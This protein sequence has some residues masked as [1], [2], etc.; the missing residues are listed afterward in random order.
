M[1]TEDKFQSQPTSEEAFSEMVEELAKEAQEE[2]EQEEKEDEV[3]YSR[4][5]YPDDFSLVSEEQVRELARKHFL[6]V[7]RSREN[8][9]KKSLEKIIKRKEENEK[10]KL[11]RI[12]AKKYACPHRG[13]EVKH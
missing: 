13:E 6:K 1:S 4:K 12:S 8:I 11:L 7:V 10:K 2:K 5:K 9:K 3:K